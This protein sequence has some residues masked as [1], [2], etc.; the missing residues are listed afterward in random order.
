MA[1]TNV[2]ICNIS[3]TLRNIM[4]IYPFNEISMNFISF[5][6]KLIYFFGNISECF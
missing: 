6:K 3:N 4:V 5:K 1:E 2:D